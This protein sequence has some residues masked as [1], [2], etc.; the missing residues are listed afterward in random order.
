MPKMWKVSIYHRPE[1]IQLHSL[2]LIDNR[3]L[4]RRFWKKLNNNTALRENSSKFTT[5]KKHSLKATLLQT[6][7]SP[8]LLRARYN[9][10]EESKPSNKTIT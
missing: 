1:G 2:G 4:N 7:S 8:S 6:I 10:Q 9:F 5:I 3:C